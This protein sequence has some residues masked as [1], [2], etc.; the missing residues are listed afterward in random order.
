M[1][2]HRSTIA[3]APIS[4]V[5]IEAPPVRIA[6]RWRLG[7]SQGR[8]PD[9]EP[10][11]LVIEI[12]CAGEHIGALACVRHP[13]SGVVEHE[14]RMERSTR[15]PDVTWHHDRERGL[16]HIRLPG[17]VT[18]AVRGNRVVY[19]TTPLLRELGW[20]GGTYEIER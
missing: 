18:A 10:R 14:R 9:A 13:R 1:A 20:S 2:P 19:A 11:S 8:T 4:P 15:D 12:E 17:L 3:E 16:L 5:R 7:P 6:I